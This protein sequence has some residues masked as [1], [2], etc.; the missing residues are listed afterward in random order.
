MLP[1]NDGPSPPRADDN[2]CSESELSALLGALDNL[3]T[4]I[5]TKNLECRYTY[6]NQLA[7]ELFGL[8]LSGITGKT[9][10]ELFAPEHCA[11]IIATDRRVLNRGESIALEETQV[12]RS[13][14]EPRTYW[15]VKAPLRDDDGR[16]IGLCG[17]RPTSP[18][19]SAPN[20]RRKPSRSGSHNAPSNAASGSMPRFGNM[21][22]T[23]L[24]WVFVSGI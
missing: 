19:T 21:R 20:V 18:P 24:I 2:K 15:T 3:G 11:E 13:R 16:I 17:S 8:P 12:L 22:Y 6:V 23:D 9:A 1:E 14:Q 7:C 4:Y 10:A 5:Y